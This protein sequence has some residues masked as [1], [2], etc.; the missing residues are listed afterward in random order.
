MVNDVVNATHYRLRVRDKLLRISHRLLIRFG[1]NL[2][3][4]GHTRNCDSKLLAIKVEMELIQN[5]SKQVSF[6]ITM[7]CSVLKP[8]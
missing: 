6:T 8:F 7:I 5:Q 4:R 1:R 3:L 2:L